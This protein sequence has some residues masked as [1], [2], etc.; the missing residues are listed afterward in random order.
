MKTSKQRGSSPALF[1][2]CALL[3]CV[4][5]ARADALSELAGFS[6][7]SGVDL[8][9]LSATGVRTERAPKMASPR[10]LSVQSVY[11]VPR[12][13]ARE[14]EILQQ[15]TPT[16][17]P[18]LHVFLHND[19]P[20]APGPENFTRLRNLPDNGPMRALISNGQRPGILQLSNAEAQKLAAATGGGSPATANFWADTLAARARAFATGGS[21][22][23]APYENGGQSIRSSQELNG[24]LQSQDKIRRQFAGLLESSGIGR[25]G[26]GMRP[27]QYWELLSVEDE[28]V[29]TLGASYNRAG[30]N[31]THQMADTLYYASGG[32]YVTLTLWQ[33]WPVNVGGKPSTLVWRG[34]M[35]S[36][37]SLAGLRGI[38]RLASESS[39]IK[40]IGRAV[41]LYRRDTLNR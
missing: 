38:E 6:N 32:Y 37:A 3:A 11:V 21:A 36:S 9:Q 25:G 31:G 7:F 40:N 13:P 24:L 1:L 16:Q 15:W 29:L 2:A 12:L 27:S 14:V 20:A 33:L 18:E 26:G 10:F 35:V 4:A 34:D 8:N 28:G 23:Q 17:H 5:H 39:M 22:A 41:N 19:L 30:A